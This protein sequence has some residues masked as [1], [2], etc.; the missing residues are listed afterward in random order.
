MQDWVSAP[1]ETILDILQEKEKTTEWF[2]AS[3]Q[4]SPEETEAFLR[5][6]IA[7]TTEIA[8]LLERVLGAPAGFWLRRDANY[9]D[10]KVQGCLYDVTFTGNLSTSQPATSIT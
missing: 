8:R 2:A 9:R 3:M 10:K 7:I 6:N 4:L 5:G 1:G